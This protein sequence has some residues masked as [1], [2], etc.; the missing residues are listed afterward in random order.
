MHTLNKITRAR[1][2]SP[3]AIIDNIIGS[4]IEPNFVICFTNMQCMDVY[5]ILQL[6]RIKLKPYSIL[7]LIDLQTLSVAFDFLNINMLSVQ[8]RLMSL[9]RIKN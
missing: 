6:D 1:H 7:S 4:T 3:K 8:F 9:R 5:I 2:I